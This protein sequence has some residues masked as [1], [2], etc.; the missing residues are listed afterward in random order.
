MTCSNESHLQMAPGNAPSPQ[1]QQQ[2][3]QQL[4]ATAVAQSTQQQSANVAN[5]AFM[6]PQKPVNGVASPTA[7]TVTPEQP[8]ANLP[9]RPQQQPC[10]QLPQSDIWKNFTQQEPQPT[11]GL[12]ENSHA[13]TSSCS[14][15]SLRYC[16][17][18]TFLT[19]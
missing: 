7:F 12:V 19:F 14:A 4:L 1:F 9:L 5:S 6:P 15:Y 8:F 13:L 16:M 17:Q 18:H 11:F 10:P 3:H 2:L